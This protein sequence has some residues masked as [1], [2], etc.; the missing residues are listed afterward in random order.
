MKELNELR[1]EELWKSWVNW[2]VEM[3]FEHSKTYQSI[4][5]SERDEWEYIKEQKLKY[6]QKLEK[7]KKYS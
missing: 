4:V 6:F 3:P 2:S 7:V 1:W 5:Q